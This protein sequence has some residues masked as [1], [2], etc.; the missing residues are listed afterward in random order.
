SG[1]RLNGGQHSARSVLLIS[2]MLLADL[3]ALHCQR[4]NLLSDQEARTFVEANHRV[5]RVIGQR[6]QLE[7]FFHLRDELRIN[8][9]E[10]PSLLEVRFQF[11]FF[12]MLPIW[13]EEI[14]S[15]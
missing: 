5:L 1:Q 12:R 8:L 15:Q 14:S 13:V 2:V 10:T 4:F 7:K 3:T 11:V 6:I 9:T